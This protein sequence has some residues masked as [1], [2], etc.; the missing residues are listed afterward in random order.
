[1]VVFWSL[2]LHTTTPRPAILGF[3]P[4]YRKGRSLAE[5]IL[6]LHQRRR[7]AKNCNDLFTEE[8]NLREGKLERSHVLIVTIWYFVVTTTKWSH[9]EKWSVPLQTHFC[10]DFMWEAFCMRW[11]IPISLM[12]AFCA[13]R[14]KTDKINLFVRASGK[15]SWLKTLVML[16]Y[17]YNN[18]SSPLIPTTTLHPHYYFNFDPI[19]AL[20]PSF[21]APCA[22]YSLIMRT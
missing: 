10:N 21:S 11:N 15:W 1:M 8:R 22:L 16:L 18:T 7:S 5:H 12:H 13:E 4:C 19:S 17:Y 2:G 6:M 20:K 3:G 9:R 14:R